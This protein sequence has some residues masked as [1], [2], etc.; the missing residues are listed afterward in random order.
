MDL[1]FVERAL[2]GWDGDAG[3][4]DEGGL[5]E[6][7]WLRTTEGDCWDAAVAILPGTGC[8]LGESR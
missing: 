1:V 2:V 4:Y 7:E 6:L 5:R 8:L 3:A